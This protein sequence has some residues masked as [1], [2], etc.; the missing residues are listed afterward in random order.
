V[1]TPGLVNA[2]SHLDLTHLRGAVPYE[3][4]FAKWAERIMHGR[5]KPGM[6]EAARKG[7]REA[8]A[9]GT[10]TFGDIVDRRGFAEVVEAFRETQARGRLFVEAIGF[11][12]EAADEI[13]EAVWDLVEMQALPGNVLTG[14]SPHAPYSVSRALLDKAVAVADGHGRPLAVHLAETLEELAF[15]RHGIGPLRELLKRAGADDPSFKPEGSAQEFLKRVEMTRA[16]LLLVHGNY[17][18]PRDVPA[19]AFV[20]YCPTAH[21]FFGHPEHP[22]IELLEEGVRVL[23][24]SDSAASGDTVDVLSETQHLARKRPDL[25]AR[26]V[27]RMATE[28]GARGLSWDSGVLAPGKLADLAAFTPALG[29]EILGAADARCVLAAVGGLVVHRVDPAAPLGETAELPTVA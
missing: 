2:H 7:I 20:V 5:K 29:H 6:P 18:R 11:R 27:F 25:Q 13:F 26:A 23:L 4:E 17:L 22:V 10:T 9:R 28:W 24:G 19:G 14:V 16:P 15:L 3:G 1:L 12:P 8:L 21:A